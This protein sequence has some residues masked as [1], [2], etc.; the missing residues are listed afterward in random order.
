MTIKIGEILKIC[1]QIKSY[2]NKI[3]FWIVGGE[4][5]TESRKNDFLKYADKLDLLHNLKWFDR[6]ENDKMRLIYS[7]I[8]KRKG[9][10][11]V[12]SKAESFGM[13]IIESLLCGC[14][15]IATNVGAIPEIN[16]KTDTLKLYNYGDLSNAV[17]LSIEML[18]NHEQVI[19]KL[20]R[21]RNGLVQSYSVKNSRDYYLLMEN[22]IQK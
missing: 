17:N 4:T 2:Q 5:S 16:S 15:V 20:T 3:E 21:D 9:L 10:C 8:S 6:I 13:S 12:T 18:G 19:D 11:L 7:T 14:P 22:L 1:S